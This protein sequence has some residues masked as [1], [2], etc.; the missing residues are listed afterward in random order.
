ME[1]VLFA[2]PLN[3]PAQIMSVQP[4]PPNSCTPA[5]CGAMAHTHWAVKC[6][7]PGKVFEKQYPSY[8][9][10]QHLSTTMHTGQKKLGW[11]PPPV[12]PIGLGWLSTVYPGLSH[13]S[14]LLALSI[15]D[16][17]LLLPYC[18]NSPYPTVCQ[19]LCG[20]GAVYYDATM[21]LWLIFSFP[22]KCGSVQGTA[23]P[24][25]SLSH[26]GC[27]FSLGQDHN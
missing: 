26:R 20:F 21:S 23:N 3:Q 4:L 15:M 10:K 7:F 6:C 27:C 14:W 11:C 17:A 8:F 2:S 13:F 22:S 12:P 5:C 25:C 9:T 19:Y 16:P 18:D 1:Y 24:R